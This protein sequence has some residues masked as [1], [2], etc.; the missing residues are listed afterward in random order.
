[1]IDWDD[2]FDNGGYVP[3]SGDLPAV[4]RRAPTPSGR[5]RGIAPTRY[6]LRSTA[7]GNGWTCS[8]RRARRPGLVVFVH[9]GYWRRFDKSVWSHL[10]AG[11][12]AHGWAVA[13]PSYTLAPQAGSAAITAEIGAARRPPPLRWLAGPIRLVGHSAGGHLVARM[14][15]ADRVRCPT[16]CARASPG[17]SR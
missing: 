4:G 11:P 12:L 1:M 3:G 6:R 5:R 17:S 2:A 14:A 10:A 7:P 8:C 15:C 9:G 16:P 13:V